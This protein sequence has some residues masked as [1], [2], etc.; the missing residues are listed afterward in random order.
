MEYDKEL[1]ADEMAELKKITDAPV[2]ATL[3]GPYLMTRSMW[4]PALS[5]KYYK[6]KERTGAGY[7]KSTETGN[8]QAGDY[9]NGCSTV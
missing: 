4:L 2:K 3:P 5:K 8:R 1:V 6:N 9:K 7:N